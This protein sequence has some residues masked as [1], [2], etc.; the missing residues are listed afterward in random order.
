MFFVQFR[1]YAS[2]RRE[3]PLGAWL[4]ST[5]ARIV[6]GAQRLD[7]QDYFFFFFAVFFFAFLL[8]IVAP[9]VDLQVESSP[10]EN[11]RGSFYGTD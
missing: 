2:R 11:S 7:C 8:A 4:L 1:R 10:A 5:P 9:H 6:G 3:R